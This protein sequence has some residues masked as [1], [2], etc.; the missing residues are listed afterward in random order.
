[1]KTLEQIQ[2]EV[3]KEHNCKDWTVLRNSL[4]GNRIKFDS[5]WMDVTKRYAIEVAKE[6]QIRCAENAKVII[7]KTKLPQTGYLPSKRFN[8]KGVVDKYSIM[9]PENLA[10]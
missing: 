1:M 7:E 3:A 4:Y 2:Q 9:D 5:I 8:M 10:I 6:T